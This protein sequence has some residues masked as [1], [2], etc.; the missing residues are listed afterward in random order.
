MINRMTTLIKVIKYILIHDLM[1]SLS[2]LKKKEI[3][4]NRRNER[5]INNFSL[6]TEPD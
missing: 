1:R 5:N 6:W 3:E 4:M 2:C